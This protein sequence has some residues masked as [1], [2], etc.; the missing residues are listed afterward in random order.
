M[1]EIEEAKIKEIDNE[2]NRTSS[3]NENIR[4]L[5]TIPGIGYY[6]ATLIYAE[7]GEIDRFPSSEKLCGYAGLVPSAHHS[8]NKTSHGKITREGTSYLRWILAECT[9]I[10]VLKY[11]SHLTRFYKRLCK[12]IGKQKALVATSRKMLKVIYWMP[13][14]KQPFIPFPERLGNNFDGV[15]AGKLRCV[16]IPS[17]LVYFRVGMD[18]FY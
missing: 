3:V 16:D 10:H 9:Q 14:N 11:D 5:T 15:H 1:I 7:I 6:S 13:K 2:I 8:G 17:P 18:F 12:R 4:I